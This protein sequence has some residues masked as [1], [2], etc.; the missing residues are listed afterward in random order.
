MKKYFLM[1]FLPSVVLVGIVLL[2]FYVSF[3]RIEGKILEKNEIRVVQFQSEIMHKALNAIVSDLLFLSGQTILQKLAKLLLSLV[4][5]R[6]DL[7]MLDSKA[8]QIELQEK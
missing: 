6:E 1:I 5:E 2:I 7:E 8:Q 4:E 3:T